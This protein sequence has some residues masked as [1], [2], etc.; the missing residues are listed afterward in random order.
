MQ[1]YYRVKYPL[2]ELRKFIKSIKDKSMS[3]LDRFNILED[4]YAMVKCGF[5]TTADVRMIN[6]V[7]IV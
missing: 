3:R 6:I 4:L 2:E 7:I 1:G 5:F